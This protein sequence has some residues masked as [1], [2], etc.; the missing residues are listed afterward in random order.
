MFFSQLDLVVS[1]SFYARVY[2]YFFLIHI[3]FQIKRTVWLHVGL[4]EQNKQ[5]N[6]RG[7]H[8][9][10]ISDSHIH[11]VVQ[12]LRAQD[13]RLV[14]QRLR[15]EKPLLLITIHF[16]KHLNFFWNE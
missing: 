16:G 6:K 4:V 15:R 8:Y 2:Q 13:E 10:Q 11:H 7:E 12:V 3:N 9:V 5:D 1:R 14:N